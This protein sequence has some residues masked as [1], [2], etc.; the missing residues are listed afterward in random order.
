MLRSIEKASRLSRDLLQFS[1]QDSGA[2]LKRIDLAEDTRDALSVVRQ[3][4]PKA[5]T[6]STGYSLSPMNG[7]EFLQ[8]ARPLNPEIRLALVAER[9]DPDLEWYQNN[10][11]IDAI[12]ERDSLERELP[13]LME[14]L[15]NETEGGK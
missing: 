12:L 2:A 10:G 8:I 14:D 9:R 5:V 13:A 11:M 6:L 15:A 3:L 1:R 7:A 4:T